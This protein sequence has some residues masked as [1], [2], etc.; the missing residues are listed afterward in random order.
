[1]GAP[2]RCRAHKEA[3]VGGPRMRCKRKPEEGVPRGPGFL[4]RPLEVGEPRW[5]L[6]GGGQSPKR[7]HPGLDTWYRHSAA[8]PRL[9]VSETVTGQPP[10]RLVGPTP[11]SP[12]PQHTPS[13]LR[14]PATLCESG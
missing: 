9:T 8:S 1:M 6:E 13:S 3:P 2:S 5:P 11:S 12:R 14:P 7:R 10:L 4:E